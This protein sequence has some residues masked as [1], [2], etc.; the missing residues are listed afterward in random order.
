MERARVVVRGGGDLAT[1]TIYKLYQCGF[2]VI[3]LEIPNPSAI[4]RKAAFCEAVF[5]KTCTVEGVTAVRADSE[6]EIGKILSENRIPLLIDEDGMWIK[7]LSPDI[8]VDGI[9][10]KRNLGTNREMAEIT[11]ALGPGFTAGK[12]VDAVIETKRG[13]TL[14]K[15][16]YEGSAIANTGIP[17]VIGGA[18]KERVIHAPASGI[19]HNLAEIGRIVEQGEL[20]AVIGPEQIPVPA[21]ICGVLRGIIRDGF[22]VREGLKIADIDP[23]LTEKENCYTISDKA[24]CIAGG[25]LEAILKIGNEKQER[26]R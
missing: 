20:L 26:G 9:L 25:V 15:V 21:S 8:L 13:H 1:G 3:I 5:D 18:G 11:V 19:I 16:I 22:L 24:R 2:Q 17:G 10:A 7:R 23:R 4:R 6:E 14:G 12:D